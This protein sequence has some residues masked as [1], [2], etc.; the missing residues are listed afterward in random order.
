MAKMSISLP[1]DVYRDLTRASEATG[2]SRSSLIAFFLKHPMQDINS[3]LGDLPLEP[4]EGVT[5]RLRSE[6][7]KR[8]FSDISVLMETLGISP[9]TNT[10]GQ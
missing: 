10:D 2:F 1:D 5:R 6:T 7:S 3:V 9:I 8:T 4:P